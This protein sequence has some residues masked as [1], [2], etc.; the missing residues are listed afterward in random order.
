GGVSGGRGGP[1]RSV[2]SGEEA[3]RGIGSG[4]GGSVTN[5]ATLAVHAVTSASA[6]SGATVCQG[7][8]AAFSTVA[9]GTGPFSY[10]WTVDGAAVGN[11]GPTFT[12]NTASLPVG[13][14]VVGVTVSGQCGLASNNTTLTVQPVTSASGPSDETACLGQDVDFA[15]VASGTGPLNYQWTLDGNAVGTNGPSLTVPT[16]S[17][18]LGDHAVAVEITGQ[19]GSVVTNA[20]TLR[21]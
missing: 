19:C 14:H 21:V 15:T 5:M 4:A 6:P 8:D 9:S 17:V 16:V 7:S 18:S 3:V 13:D 10:Q 2:V 11:N 12:V 20:A 1:A